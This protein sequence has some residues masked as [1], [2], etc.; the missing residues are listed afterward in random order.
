MSRS[1]SSQNASTTT[2]TQ[3]HPR[4]PMSGCGTSAK[5][6]TV[7]SSRARSSCRPVW[8]MSK[9]R[10]GTWR[11]PSKPQHKRVRH[12]NKITLHMIRARIA[13]KQQSN[14]PSLASW[15]S[16][17]SSTDT[18]TCTW[19]ACTGPWRSKLRRNSQVVYSSMTSPWSASY[20]SAPRSLIPTSCALVK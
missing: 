20:P 14:C 18:T 5:I 4:M 9:T 10:K 16:P 3:Q 15:K 19:S 11:T 13:A 2:A 12:L 1:R 7:T 6:I 17:V 8:S